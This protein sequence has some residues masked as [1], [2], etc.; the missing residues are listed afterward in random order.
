SAVFQD[1]PRT[2]VA[3]LTSL[4]FTQR[5]APYRPAPAATASI[6]VTL[7]LASASLAIN[8]ATAPGRS[9]PWTRKLVLGPTSLIFA[10]RAVARK[11]VGSAG[12]KSICARR[13]LGKPEKASKLTPAS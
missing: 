9:S 3:L 8:S 6:A 2:L 13:P 4:G 7:I 1:A 12:I 5:I 10:F 11:A